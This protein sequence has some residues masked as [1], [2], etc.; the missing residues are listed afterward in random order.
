[1]QLWQLDIVGRIRLVDGTQLSAVTGIDDHS[2][3]CVLAR[4]LPRATAQPVYD[5]LRAALARHGVPQA[6]L[7]DNGKVVTARFGPGP[8]PVLF[9]RVCHDNGIRHCSPRRTRR[10]PPASS[11]GCTRRCAASSSTGTCSTRSSRPRPPWTPGWR[12]TT[13]PGPTGHR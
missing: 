1:M 5:A 12:T 6:I 7:T 3:F 13:P 11:S 2:R 8:G 4:L 9:D 10:P